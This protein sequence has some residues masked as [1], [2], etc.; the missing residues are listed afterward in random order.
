MGALNVAFGLIS[1]GVSVAVSTEM[2]SL[3]PAVNKSLSTP[4]CTTLQVAG[5]GLASLFSAGAINL[6]ILS[7]NWTIFGHA[8]SA[9]DSI[10]LINGLL[11]VMLVVSLG[12]VPSVIAKASMPETRPGL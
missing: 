6:G 5:G 1:A 12:L 3:A 11:V 2:M 7:V 4:L 9:Y 10:L 8:R